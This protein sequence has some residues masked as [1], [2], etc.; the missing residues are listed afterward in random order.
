MRDDPS[1]IIRASEGF[2]CQGGMVWLQA[3]D[4]SRHETG[5][6]IQANGESLDAPFQDGNSRY[7]A[8]IAFVFHTNL[9]LWVSVTPA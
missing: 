7:D 2:W 5:R 6:N 3:F 8:T 9:P 4:P 1:F